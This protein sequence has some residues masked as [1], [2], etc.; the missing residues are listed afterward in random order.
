MIE[1]TLNLFQLFGLCLLAAGCGWLVGLMH[2]QK[3]AKLKPVG[4]VLHDGQF[5]ASLFLGEEGLGYASIELR[6]NKNI[7]YIRKDDHERILKERVT[8]VDRQDREL[9]TTAVNLA[10]STAPSKDYLDI[11]RFLKGETND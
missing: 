1:T 10:L 8:A 11:Y 9:R 2:R 3:P 7:L 6:W 5:P 4:R